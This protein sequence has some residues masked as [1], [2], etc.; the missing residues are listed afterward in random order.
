M[1]KIISTVL[2]TA[3]YDLGKKTRQTEKKFGQWVKN[4]FLCL[5][6]NI[7]FLCGLSDVLPQFAHRS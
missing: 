1:P 7:K 4:V 3:K 2:K 5:K 6:F